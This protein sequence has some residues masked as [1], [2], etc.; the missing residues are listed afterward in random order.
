M[1][2]LVLLLIGVACTGVAYWLI[3]DR[4]LSPLVMIPAVVAA[5]I[6]ASHITKREAKR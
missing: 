3:T 4:G 6:G 2:S 5:T 1:A